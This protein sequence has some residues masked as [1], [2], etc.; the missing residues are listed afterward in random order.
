MLLHPPQPHR[1]GLSRGI[2]NHSQNEKEPSVKVVPNW[3]CRQL[4]LSTSASD[5]LK[6]DPEEHS[7]YNHTNKL[8]L[9]K[10]EEPGVMCCLSVHPASTLK[11]FFSS[12]PCKSYFNFFYPAASKSCTLINS[13]SINSSPN[14]ILRL[15]SFQL[16]CNVRIT[17]FLFR[18]M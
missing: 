1:P 2:N 9:L 4:S 17:H 10:W 3:I 6:W 18:R 16:S 12:Q 11:G 13:R 7:A 8:I 14:L 15:I 5:L